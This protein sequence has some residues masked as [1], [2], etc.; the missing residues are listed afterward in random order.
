M[1]VT[2]RDVNSLVEALDFLLSHRDAARAMGERARE[3]VLQNY[4]WEKNAE[5][6]IEVYREVLGDT[7]RLSSCKKQHG[8]N[9]G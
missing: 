9:S 7:E 8:A 2:P 1:L 6:T 5:M 4:T 3:V